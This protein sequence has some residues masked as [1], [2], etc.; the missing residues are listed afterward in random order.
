MS[1]PGSRPTGPTLPAVATAPGGRTAPSL[2]RTAALLVAALVAGVLAVAGPLPAAQAVASIT[3]SKS[4]PTSVLAGSTA[5]FTLTAGNPASNP[6]AVPEYNLSFRDVLPLGLTYVAGSTT[7]ASAG[8]PTVTLN[9]SGQQ[10]LVWRNVSDLQ[11]ADSF[12]LGFT[13]RADQAVLPVGSNFANLG[14]A[15]ANTDPRR[16][17]AFDA[18]GT[19]V[20]GTFT[21]SASAST[22]AIPVS[23][24]QISKAEPSPESELLRGIHTHPTVYTL[25]VRNTG[26]AATNG[27]VVT[28]Y[29]PASL[30]F[31]G[32][33]GVDNSAAREYPGAP[34]LTATPSVPGCRTPVSVETVTNPPAD[35]TT[36]Y[37]AGVYTKVTWNLGN[38][39]A[40]ATVTLPYAAGVPLRANTAT[41]TPGPAPTPASLGQTANL[42]NNNGA[43]TREGPAE[44]SATNVARASGTYTGTVAAGGTAATSA[45][46][47]RTVTIED[48]RMRKSASTSQFAT[49]GR[50]QYTLTIETSEYVSASGTLITDII[51]NGMCPL[52]GAGTNYVPGAPVD[53]N[54]TG[55]TA[56]S[57]PYTSV[58]E[59]PD[60]SFTVQF[61]ALPTIAAD[62][63][64]TVT[65]WAG[66]RDLYLGTGEPTSS[67]D[68]FTN[69]VSL[70]ST[71]TP[72]PATG[73]IGTVTVTDT[74]S[75]TIGTDDLTL[76]KTIGPRSQN[77]VCGTDGAGYGEPS[78]FP[79]AQ[80]QFRKGDVICFKLRVDFPT[81]TRTRNPVITDFLPAGTQYVPGS[82]VATTNDRRSSAVL[83]AT[84]DSL[85]WR[86]GDQVGGNRFVDLGATFEWV[87][88]VTVT[89]AAPVGNPD[90]LGNAMK[91]RAEDSSGR[92]RSYRDQVDF[93]VVPAAPVSVLKGIQSI[94]VPA[95]GPNGLNSNV[96]GLPVR[97]GSTVRFRI[98]VTNSGVAGGPTG[99]P[100]GG[101]DVWDVLPAGITCAAITSISG[102]VK[103]NGVPVP[104]APTAT[105]TNPGQAGHPTFT[106]STTQSAIR[107]RQVIDTAQT[108]TT[109]TIAPGESFTYTYDMRL[110]S[111]TSVG[112]TFTNTAAVRS[113]Q[114]AANRANTVATYFPQSNID[115]TV[116]VASQDAP[117]ASD[118][119][120]VV[121]PAVSVGKVG[122]TS[123][124]ETNNSTPDQATIGELVTYRYAVTVPDRTAIFNGSLTDALPTGFAIV[125]TPTAPAPA[126]EFCPSAPTPSVADPLPACAAPGTVPAGVTLNATNGTVT[127][128]ATYDNTTAT[129]QRFLV[130][131]TVRVGST[132]LATGS[133]ATNA[134][135]SARFNSRATLNGTALPQVQSTYTVNLRQPGPAITKTNN[136]TTPKAGGDVVT[137]TVTAFNRNTA[138]TTTNRPPLHDAFIIDCIPSGLTFQA[139]GANPGATPVPGNGTNGCAAGTT[140][141]VWALGTI[142][143]STTGTART[144][145]ATVN[146]A[147]VGGDSY[148][149]TARLI[150]GTLNDGKPTFDAPDN[151]NERTYSVS[152]TSTVTVAGNA[153]TKTANPTT[154][155]IG[156]TS[157]FTMTATVPANVNFYAP[158]LL[159][160][161][162]VGQ[163]PPTA[164]TW[165]C[166]VLPSNASCGTTGTLLPPAVQADGS[167]FYGFT[168]PDLLALPNQRRITVTYQ[169][170]I[171]DVPTNVAGR[172][173]TDTVQ[174]A[175][176][177]TPGRTPTS[178]PATFDRLGSSASATVTVLEPSL[179]ITK[180]V[181]DTTPA[182]GDTF[183]Y[184]VRVTNATGATRS[185]AY[186]TVVTD[187]VPTGVVV[188]AVNGGGTIAGAGPNGGGT[189]TWP[190]S[191]LPG[192][193]NAGATYTLTY[194]ARLAASSSLTGAAL[195]NTARNTTYLSLPSGGRT[196]T[197]GTAT[198]T[199]TPDFPRLVTTKAA[200]SGAP[201]YIGTSYTWTVTVTN[202]GTA[203]AFGVD[204]VDTLPAS[205]LYD[206][207]SARVSIDGAPSVAVEPATSGSPQQLTWTNLGTL[208]PG[209]SLT[210]TYRATPQPGVVT[211]PGVGSSVPHVN[212]AVSSGDDA[213]G[214]SG[215]ADGPYGGTPATASTRIDSADVRVAK[216]HA[217]APVAGTAF[218]WTLAVSNAGPDTAV[219]PFRVDD[220]IEAPATFVSATGTGWSCAFA[221]GAVSCTRTN[222]GDTLASGASFPPITVRVALAADLADGTV[223]S[224]TATVSARTYDPQTSNNTDNDTATVT[225]RAD[226]ALD[227][228]RSTAVVAGQ[229]ATYTLDVVNNG[230][231][232]S[233]GPI[234]VTDTLPAGSTFRSASGSGWVCGASGGTLTC[235]RAADLLVGEAAPQI[236]VVVG[237]PSSQTADVVNSATV[238]GT[239]TDPVPGNNTDSDTA[240][241]TLLADLAIQKANVGS[242]VAGTT[243]TYRLTVD[244]LGPSDAASPVR[245]VDTLPAGL[246]YVSKNDVDG[247]WTCGAAGQVVTCTLTGPLAAGDQVAVEIR[248]AVASSVSGTISNTA[249]VSS[250]T[251][252][253]VP[254]NNTDTESTAFVGE[255]DLAIDKTGPATA[256]A[257][258][259]VTWS[260]VV[261]NNGPSDSPGTIRVIDTLPTGT[262]FVSAGGTGW[263]CTESSG[264][265]TCTRAAALVAGGAAPAISIVVTID[266]DAG[267]A[268]L[269]NTASVDGP[270]TDP[271]P[272]NNTDTADV[273][274]TDEAELALTKATT[275]ADPVR[276]GEATEFTITVDN[277]GPS[278]A[279][280][281]VVVDT[282]PAGLIPVSASGAGWTCAAPVG[283]TIQ[284]TRPTQSPGSSTIVVQ[285]TVAPGVLDGTTL[286]NSATVS[287]T[288]P[289][290]NPGNNTG[291]SPVDVVAEA[292]LSIVKSHTGGALA[293]SEKAFDLEVRNDGPSDAQAPITVVDT[294]PA[295]L[296]FVTSSGPW[297]CSAAGQVVT[298]TE[299]SGDPLAA[300]ADAALLQ[301]TVLVD[302]AAAPG[303]YT[304]SAEVSSPTTDPVPGNNTGTDGLVVSQLADLAVTKTH[305]GPVRVGDPLTFTL[306]VSNA[307]PSTAADVRLVD[308]L[309]AGLT[310]VSADGTGWT[311]AE[312]SGVVT[313]DLG[314]PLAPGATADPVSVVA[315]VEAS[316]YPSVT[317]PAEVST[318]TP[319]TSLGD[320][321]A[322]DVVTVPPLVNLAV[323]KTHAAPFVV[324]ATGTWTVAVTNEGPT[325]D[326]GPI[327]LVDTLPT[328][329]TFSGTATTDAWTCAVAGQVVT[330][331]LPAGL[332]AG[333]STSLD[334]VVDV[335]PTAVPE[336][337]NTVTVSTPSEETSLNDNTAEDRVP[338]EPLVLLSM[339]K[340]LD[341]FDEQTRV[342]SWRITVVNDGPN[343]SVDPIVVTDDLPKELTFLSASGTGWTCVYN[344]GTVT[345][346]YK[347]S[348]AAGSSASVF[349]QTVVEGEGGQ[350]VVNN[351]SLQLPEGT[352]TD[353]DKVDVPHDGLGPT[354]TQAAM[355]LM[356]GLMLLLLGAAA[357]TT[358]RA[359]VRRP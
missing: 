109:Q 31:L 275:G 257:G 160:R 155:T 102:I 67:G 135:N 323:T 42:D 267:P 159:D 29:L 296:S 105:C 261:T 298:C 231:S 121:T 342:A 262:S 48:V 276:A 265:V 47:R 168:G 241:P 287:T 68:S 17:P 354:G 75:S 196:Y 204:V 87:F 9:G 62:G 280:S 138:T 111:P 214:A 263:A 288:T 133:N 282:M 30:E 270:V 212:T 170:T 304:N 316:A 235:T 181:S 21:E 251:T 300:G 41:F 186:G 233:R 24:L 3:L 188:T 64:A 94:D 236:T 167:S 10:V 230:P 174:S 161:I 283:Q 279:D 313:C 206:A 82:A 4:G 130:T 139:Y 182:P 112:R 259:Q 301:I 208:Q 126:L 80:T 336:V 63:T 226:L 309:P 171:L 59:N 143:P 23:A 237:I 118:T 295:G 123:I 18:T 148:V 51:P 178:S 192:P 248:V 291:T 284:C 86:L 305:T 198:A 307:G 216:T 89:N 202:S 299:D 76:D 344:G 163:G 293:G 326:P 285:A 341:G 220:T 53:C 2:R 40:G 60:G 5:A 26:V 104:V 330:C 306:T 187:T 65:Y 258:E 353:G 254:G 245:I 250:P 277:A 264:T 61:Q 210:V 116:P 27:V 239:T 358:R 1:V 352:K 200:T 318:S 289:G 55:A 335:L 286:V 90:I 183:T 197:G 218:D 8:E 273:V 213:T 7:P 100:V 93:T 56:P 66:M 272:G 16:I 72:V 35:G 247:A 234:T 294:L 302:P 332:A 98:D 52:G 195:V 124:T 122:T 180:S 281:V 278:T 349:V 58:A 228:N 162:P 74:S 172:A 317:N 269:T 191:A 38:L 319:E 252:D 225:T 103:S 325:A 79:A 132:A 13:A 320:N 73:V 84:A 32:C 223:L 146:P 232:V 205:W 20:A 57:T 149:N 243:A 140:R 96:D 151:P 333:A 129:P 50:V 260:L 211:S 91:L 83:T 164:I 297:T 54:G 274:V 110:P 242:V 99:Y 106:G 351:A 33:G 343:D 190:A 311:C 145:T 119:S 314:S 327:T 310:Y 128:P 11:V 224:N 45:D 173:L 14:N 153:V 97:E 203:P 12:A 39:A 303:T 244:N 201:A 107:W 222:A 117:A 137:Y 199:V 44:A 150:G 125:T 175:W 359:L 6:D 338:V 207:A 144:Y 28:D 177:S 134:V 189:I 209:R 147:A 85:S 324:G 19:V 193:L 350:V 238:N 131:L 331:T 315:T 253:P 240:T 345:C 321:T 36:T 81:L 154:R 141:L 229:D 176:F 215:N 43:S 169:S 348:L 127:F 156:Q 221:S 114:A 78:S 256:L 108:L 255:A 115:T 357:L 88:A 322:T 339:T 290:D 152:A 95:A 157:T 266:P 347:A 271:V 246:T 179:T 227:K 292:D 185:P 120:S 71:T 329:V 268:T 165:S 92:G 194:T 249:E 334:L 166:V 69:R 142:Q 136:A 337:V 46:T 22:G 101:L 346:T 49:L 219:G 113:F 15:Y 340:R 217:A 34:S 312:A 70:T 25:T 77:G 37:P 308:T 356:I 184:T 328:G 355:L 158:T